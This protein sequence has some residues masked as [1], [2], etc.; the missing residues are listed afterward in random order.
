MLLLLLAGMA[1][2]CGA[3]FQRLSV[4]RGGA[5]E[6]RA[7]V[8]AA[9]CEIAWS[10]VG[11]VWK[12]G[13]FATTCHNV[14]LFQSAAAFVSQAPSSGF[15]TWRNSSDWAQLVVDGVAYD[16]RAVTN[17]SWDQLLQDGIG[18]VEFQ[19]DN[20]FWPNPD[21]SVFGGP[22]VIKM[23]LRHGLVGGLLEFY[24]NGTGFWTPDG[25]KRLIGSVDHVWAD[26][27]ASY[28]A[29]GFYAIESFPILNPAADT[30]VYVSYRLAKPQQVAWSTVTGQNPV[31]LTTFAMSLVALKNS[32]Q[33]VDEATPS[34][35]ANNG[36]VAAIVCACVF[37]VAVLVGVIVV[38]VK[39]R[40]PLPRKPTP[41]EQLTDAVML[42]MD[43]D[44][45]HDFD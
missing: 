11:G 38:A 31:R 4:A 39:C 8:I 3:D 35:L 9:G 23:E 27:V 42:Y 41:V 40:K 32:V 19:L 5:L 45:E 2:L 44:E 13:D 22:C 14:A 43:N 26:A 10:G 33:W 17:S 7:D 30:W 28:V 34:W 6:Y 36:K 24:A 20:I 21:E 12:Q 25:A 29:S 18:N 37:G 1:S 15:Y 16:T